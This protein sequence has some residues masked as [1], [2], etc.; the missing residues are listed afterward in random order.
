[1][2]AWWRGGGRRSGCGVAAAPGSS[3]TPDGA[4]LATVATIAMIAILAI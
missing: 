4:I 1:M 2:V 3:P